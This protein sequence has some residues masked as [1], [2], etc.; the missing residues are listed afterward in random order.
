MHTNHAIRKGKWANIDTW[1]F[2]HSRRDPRRA[3]SLVSHSASGS[4][5]SGQLVR[6]TASSPTY[7]DGSSIHSPLPSVLLLVLAVRELVGVH[8]LPRLEAVVDGGL[9]HARVTRQYDLVV[10]KAALQSAIQVHSTSRR[11]ILL[12]GRT[13]SSAHWY[14]YATHYALAGRTAAREPDVF[15]CARRKEG[16]GGKYVD[17]FLCVII[18]IHTYIH[19]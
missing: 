4:Y 15:C 1:R 17:R 5:L 9:A 10:R 2:R 3:I 8:E 13:C 12:H 6:W 16:R 18:I 11:R 7:R 19:V 14:G